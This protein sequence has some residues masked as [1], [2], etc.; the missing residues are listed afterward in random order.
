MMKH[1]LISIFI[2]MAAG[3]GN[4][5][6]AQTSYWNQE[7][8]LAP[9]RLPLPPNGFKPE[10]IDLNGD[11]R[12][13]A[14]KSM[15][16]NTPI[17]WLDDDGNM[18]KGDREGDMVNDCLLIDRNHDGF[19]GGYGDLI[20]DWVDSDGDGRAD[21]QI[22][23]DY[24]E[25]SNDGKWGQ[26]HYM[27]V[28]DMDHDNVFNYINFTDFKIHAWDH[29][30][31]SDFYLDYAGQT[32]FMKIHRSTTAMKDLRLNWENP[33]LFYDPDKDGL[34]EMAL[35]VVDGK[36][37][38]HADWVSLVIDLD[39]DNRPGDEFDFDMTLGF[40]G[41]GFD[42]SNMRHAIHNVRGLPEADKFFMD[43]RY[44]QLKELVYP[45]HQQALNATFKK[46]KWTR[47]NFVYDED[48]D[49]SRWERVEFYDPAKDP[50]KVGWNQGGI[51]NNKQSDASGDRGEWDMDN[52]GGGRLYLSRFDGRLHLYG[53]ERGVWR[54]DQNADYYQGWDRMW[55]GFKDPKI[56]GTVVYTDT[57]GNGFFDH[58]EYDL[59]GDKK[60][61]T[62]IDFHELGI[63]DTCDIIDV[64]NY[65]Y[66][67]WQKLAQCMADG[68]WT[69]AQ[70]AQEVA[71]QRGLQTAWYAKWKQARSLREK[72]NN[73]FWLSFYIYKDLEQT[74][75][76]EARRAYYS[77]D[78]SAVATK[79][80]K[81]FYFLNDEEKAR[82][83]RAAKTP[84][85]QRIIKDM[86]KQVQ[87]RRR[88]SLTVPDVPGGHMHD[89]FCPIH[90]M[91]LTFNWDKPHAHRCEACGKDYTGNDHY[92][93]AWIN[94]M[95]F[96]NHDYLYR[97]M[98]L[99][100]ATGQK[101]YAGYIRDMLL[102]YASKY[103]G[104]FEHNNN[105]IATDKHSGKAFA[106][107][108][109]E[110]SWGQKMAMIYSVMKPT[111]S[112]QDR[113][114]IEQGYLR[115]SVK[116]IM[117]RKD[118]GNWQMW[119]NGGIAAMG[120]ALEDDSIIDVA[121]NRPG[122]GY[123]HMINVMKNDDGWIAEGSPHYHYYPL[124]SLIFTA[125]TVRCRGIDL[126]DRDMHDMFS[127]PV[128][129]VYP[130]LSWA[131]QSDGWYG[132]NLLAQTALYEVAAT[133]MK[134]P[135]FRQVLAKSYSRK[136]RLD[137]EALLNG[138][139]I[140][141]DSTP[142]VQKSFSYNTSGFSVLRDGKNTLVFKFGGEGIG[143]G[144]PDKLSFTIHNGDKEVISDFGT[145]GY[146]TPDYL[147]W[148][149]RTL[150]HNTVVVDGKDQKKSTG[151]LLRFVARKDGGLV[152]GESTTA[153]EGVRMRRSM[154]LHNGE[155][156]DRY[157][158]QSG[159]EH[160]Y[161]Y[162]LLFNERPVI[163]GTGTAATAGNQAPY[164][165]LKHVLRY[166]GAKQLNIQTSNLSVQLDVKEGTVVEY[167][168]GEAPGIPANPTVSDGP[169]A[170]KQAAQPCYPLIIRVKGKNME[171]DGQW[172]IQ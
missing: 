75:P 109:D 124:E 132:A 94:L 152:E 149:K 60:F 154:D 139:A 63:S 136:Q 36:Q 79:G 158:C 150:S 92:D 31:L 65:Q 5:A 147:G 17:L 25:K 104:W 50:F 161:E 145:S 100:L 23:I 73:G 166:D 106:Q 110:A 27:I 64:S 105:R 148:Y 74:M 101:K 61:E 1:F 123:H 119:H 67:D 91:E 88:H 160:L 3:M 52:S 84:W 26:G 62:I 128:K 108:L 98:W 129:G 127:E 157:T 163:N 114:K 59:D 86:E 144:H 103:D 4:K 81:G 137:P 21:M 56:F 55:M 168:V 167:L 171:V 28:M 35:R 156:T 51:D 89:Y 70:H 53:A 162:V 170:K 80:A 134:D 141:P 14:I 126:F 113:Q 71:W 112:K 169:G 49:C 155:V 116:M 78:W 18:K 93:W 131:A 16:G 32:A 41:P 38:G 30:G 90:N 57:D 159:E 45:D 48:D 138:Q 22:V 96:K 76:T 34:S 117:A 125:L 8:H 33:F 68:I 121:M 143:H 99:Y 46:G 29:A 13:D 82:I 6:I 2:M 107:S 142:L 118:G 58:I 42:Y 54:I 39:N 83:R 164:D 87:E 172:K 47:V 40:Q 95:H 120:V 146:M 43:P 11:G 12:P 72:Y 9:L 130:D 69:K 97:C 165:R 153:Y 102:D 133:Y 85:G 66:K 24:P 20:I 37:D 10:Q 115:P 15:A 140:E 151:R 111:L 77:G 122:Y 7:T 44:R 19:Y 135:I